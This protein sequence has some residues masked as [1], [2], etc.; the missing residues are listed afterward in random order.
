MRVLVAD[1]NAEIRLL[2]R[3]M[4]R[5][6][7]CEVVAAAGGAEA[8]RA[9][10]EGGFELFVC[11][12][13]MPDKDGLATIRELHQAFPDLRIIAMSGAAGGGP[14]DPLYAAR[15]AGADAVLAKPFDL[16]GLLE[17]MRGALARP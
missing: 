11:D 7:G 15:L 17:A 16:H 8:V 5:C 14:G 12:L 2:L 9:C 13:L 10:R 1:D 6:H 3:L 4:L